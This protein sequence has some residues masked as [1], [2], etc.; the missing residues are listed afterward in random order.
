MFSTAQHA[1]VNLV[2]RGVFGSGLFN[3]KRSRDDSED[4]DPNEAK[5]DLVDGI[6]LL[7]DGAGVTP[8]QVAVWWVLAQPA[9]TTMLI[10]I[11]SV[12]HLQSTVRLRD[13]TIA[14]RRCAHRRGRTDS[15]RRVTGSD[16]VVIGS[17]PCGAMAAQ[18]LVAAGLRVTMLD[19]GAGPAARRHRAR[20][21]DGH[22]V[23][24]VQ[25]SKMRDDRHRSAARPADRV[26]LEHDA[27]RALQLLDVGGSTVRAGGLHRRAMYGEGTNGRSATTISSRSTSKQRKRW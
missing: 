10:G 19:A 6:R 18:E 22:V 11:N 13:G 25:P 8:H 20:R 23:R 14:A 24:W 12:E 16:V 3:E 9:V 1:G 21:E 17:G 7:A 5:R 15:E 2:A 4:H 27:G 26:V